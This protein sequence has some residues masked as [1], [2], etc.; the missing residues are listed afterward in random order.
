M[1]NCASCGEN[2]EDNLS[3]GNQ[4]V[5]T[6]FIA[7]EDL[8]NPFEHELAVAQCKSCG[9][10]QQSALFPVNE[11][12]PPYS[13]LECTEPEA[14]LDQLMLDL[15]KKF[16][17]NESSKVLGISWKDDTSLARLE[18]KTGCKISRLRPA[19]DL[20]IGVENS[21][22]ES[23]QEVLSVKKSQEY[24]SNE[25]KSDFV[26]ARHILEHAHH[27]KD[28]ILGTIELCKPNG[29]IMFEIP[30]CERAIERLDYTTVWE[31]HTLYFTPETFKGIFSQL[32]YPIEF[33]RCAEY[34][35]ENSLI[36]V[37]KN[38]PT[39]PLKIDDVSLAKEKQ[40]YKNFSKKFHFAQ[41]NLHNFLTQLKNEGKII[42][43]FGAAH[44]SIIFINLLGIAEWVDFVID[45]NSDKRNYLLP[46]SKLPILPSS[47]I[48]NKDGS[49]HVC[50]LSLSPTSEVKVL[51]KFSGFLKTG[52]S[53]YSIFP[54]NDKALPI[55]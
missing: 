20:G 32:G 29:F 53:F 52:G 26:M 33:F 15:A 30:D 49:N 45:D 6:H 35:L 42:S 2:L 48:N 44:M 51:P 25:D 37:I 27:L 46:G 5:C 41:S 39:A 38:S 10:V 54:G 9:L 14:H 34:S 19:E 8:T 36:V 24:L 1:N 12:V 50:I 55:Y 31:E 13:W 18:N 40:R 23:V 4:I 43:V 7:K 16:N 21:D 11:L 3:F 28:F 22:I 17:I 47:N